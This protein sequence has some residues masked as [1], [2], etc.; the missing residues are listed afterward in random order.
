MKLKPVALGLSLGILWGGV[1]FLTSWLSY[2]TG[3]GKSFLDAMAGSLYPG[4]TIS[5]L[6][7]FL[8]LVYG[9]IDLFIGGMLLG[10]IYNRIAGE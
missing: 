8:G 1:L 2:F 6:G 5:P 4:Y 7:S 10:W 9:F 3:Y